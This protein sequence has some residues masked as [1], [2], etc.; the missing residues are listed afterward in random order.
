MYIVIVQMQARPEHLEEFLAG[1]RENSRASLRDEP[2]CLRFDVLQNAQEPTRFTLYEIYRDESA[3]S[4][5][6]RAAPHYLAWREI[7]ARVLVEGGQSNL[8]YQAAFPDDL[9]Q[10]L[11]AAPDGDVPAH[12]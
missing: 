7:A 6:H 5:E 9:S 12:S 1:M 4:Q 10:A 2:G 11:V 8:F 3:F